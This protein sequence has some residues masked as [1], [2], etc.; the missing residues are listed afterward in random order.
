MGITLSTTGAFRETGALRFLFRRVHLLTTSSSQAPY[1]SPCRKAAGL[2]HS[3][4][5]PLPAK[6]ALRGPLFGGGIPPSG[7]AV[8]SARRIALSA[9]SARQ[10]RRAC[11]LRSSLPVRLADGCRLICIFAANRC[12]CPGQ[13]AARLRKRV[14]L[15]PLPPVSVPFRLFLS[16]LTSRASARRRSLGAKIPRKLP[17]HRCFA[18]SAEQIWAEARRSP[19]G[20]LLYFQGLERSIGPNLPAQTGRCSSPTRFNLPPAALSQRPGRSFLTF[21]GFLFCERETEKDWR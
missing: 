8:R 9:E 11:G 21:P 2:A 3:A 5:P 4:A 13:P 19:Q 6:Q 7:R 15:E 18:V 17:A 20:I 10:C 14:G 12:P 1:P 16:R